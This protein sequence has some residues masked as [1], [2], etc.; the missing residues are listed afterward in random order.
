M[1]IALQ[2]DSLDYIT[3]A[4]ALTA[5]I[6]WIVALFKKLFNKPNLRCFLNKTGIL[7]FDNSGAGIFCSLTLISK[8]CD[9]VVTDIEINLFKNETKENRIYKLKWVHLHSLSKKTTFSDWGISSTDRES[10]QPCPLYL[11]KDKPVS[12]GIS[13]ED[14]ALNK[15]FEK[16]ISEYTS[17][18]NDYVKD[19]M[20][21]KFRYEEC[22]HL[23]EIV[24]TDIRGRQSRFE[25][26]FS[27]PKTDIEKL[28]YNATAICENLNNPSD[29]RQLYAAYSEL[30]K[31]DKRSKG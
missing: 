6:P 28:Q 4:L 22:V 17:K 27:L 26:T 7:H 19:T 30:K 16:I 29:K 20:L 8:K 21:T 5:L 24:F 11:T 9:N 1:D 14:E 3:L 12:Y 25:Y 18:G 31:R 13:F 15:E 10:M 23:L 2:R